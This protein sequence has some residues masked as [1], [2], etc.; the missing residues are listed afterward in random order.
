[1]NKVVEKIDHLSYFYCE[2]CKTNTASFKNHSCYWPW[3][4]KVLNYFD[5]AIQILNIENILPSDVIEH[6]PSYDLC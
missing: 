2:G 5:E 4:I 3:T 1:M 6:G